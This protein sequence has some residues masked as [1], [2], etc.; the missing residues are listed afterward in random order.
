MR[1]V[2]YSPQ[3]AGPQNQQ[4]V[5]SDYSLLNAITRLSLHHGME[6]NQPELVSAQR[7]DRVTM[8]P[9]PMRRGVIEVKNL[10]AWVGEF[11][12]K[13][14]YDRP[15]PHFGDVNGNRRNLG[16]DREAAG[17]AVGVAVLVCVRRM[18]SNRAGAGSSRAQGI[19]VCVAG[20]GRH[21]A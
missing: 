13:Q 11:L 7:I 4:I 19:G 14:G 12:K 1:L 3:L 20:R 8:G 17:P 21:A 2:S 9:E 10:D 15:I 16:Q 18:E 6:N 5:Y